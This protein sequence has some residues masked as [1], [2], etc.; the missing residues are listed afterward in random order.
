MNERGGA[1]G[2]FED[3][4]Q[5]RLKH[6]IFPVLAQQTIGMVPDDA[7]DVVEFIPDRWRHLPGGVEF[8]DG[9]MVL[10]RTVLVKRHHFFV[11]GFE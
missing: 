11:D 7:K 1:L 5:L 9:F 2:R 3:Q 4:L 6:R 10:A 8:V